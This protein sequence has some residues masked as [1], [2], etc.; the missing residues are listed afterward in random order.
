MR[1]DA[2]Q[3]LARLQVALKMMAHY[4]GLFLDP[5]YTAK[6]FAG[7]PGLLQEGQIQPGMRVLFIHTDGVPALFAYQDELADNTDERGFSP[8]LRLRSGV[9][10]NMDPVNPADRRRGS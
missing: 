2:A 9:S 4:E 1:R 3:Q 5:V 7:V 8:T 10:R 6:A